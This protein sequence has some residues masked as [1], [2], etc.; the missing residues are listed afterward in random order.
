ML[1]M[2]QQ[3]RLDERGVSEV[4][5]SLVILLVVSVAGA[6]LYSYSMDTFSASWSSFMLHTMGKEEHAKERFA[7]IAVWWDSS[8]ELNLTILNYGM[9]E[10]AIDAVYLDGRK[11]SVNEGRGIVTVSGAVVNV[12][13]AS[14]I[15]I[16]VNETYQIVAVSERGTRDEVH[17]KA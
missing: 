12:K 3:L 5:A 11:A 14:P 4:V 7:V 10:L 13:F 6:A 16:Q 9:I 1:E 17:W 15:P 2:L 8:S